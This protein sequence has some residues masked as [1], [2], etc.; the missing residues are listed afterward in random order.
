MFQNRFLEKN[1]SSIYQYLLE[2]LEGIAII[3]EI[4]WLF[5]NLNLGII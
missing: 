4:Y 3:S 2:R 5:F 1:L